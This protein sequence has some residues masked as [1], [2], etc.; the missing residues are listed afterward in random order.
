MVRRAVALLLAVAAVIAVG[1]CQGKKRERGAGGARPAD[2]AS[3][4]ADGAEAAGSGAAP[5]P[6]GTEDGAGAAAAGAGA[7]AGSARAPA[8]E[9]AEAPAD[10][11]KQIAELGAIPAWQAVI[12]RAQL[13]ARR[14]QNGIVYGR[15]G[16]AILVPGP[17]P[18]PV[19]GGAP[20]DAGLVPSPYVWLVDDTEGNGA[21]GIRIA[22]G[23][24]IE[25]AKEGDRIAASG[26]WE[27]DEDRRWYWRAGALQHL[28]PPPPGPA[29]TPPSTPPSTPVD[30]P[31]AVPGHVPAAG[32]LPPGAKPI[33]QAKDNDLVYFQ[34]VGPMPA[35]DGDGW[36][37]GAQL[38]DAPVALLLLPGERPSYGGQDMRTPDER[39]QLKRQQTYWVRLGKIRPQSPGKPFVVR[40][41][42]APVRVQ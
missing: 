14:G 24:L 21:L 16:P 33:K 15:V 41:R 30:P 10:P 31:A 2:A 40:A 34:L 11:S 32:G 26:A 25:K 18:D 13:L 23:K 12:D 17:A 36:L 5:D 8:P 9:D 35:N 6:A 38:H 7:G 28:P 39:W 4:P 22:L 3:A 27:L 29:S 37:V 1:A 20:A 19:D 42:T